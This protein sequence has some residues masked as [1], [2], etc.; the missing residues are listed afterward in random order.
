MEGRAAAAAADA[1]ERAPL[2][3][4]GHASL[5]SHVALVLPEMAK[6][7]EFDAVV[8]A[9][10]AGI[11]SGAGGAGSTK[12]AASAAG[13]GAAAAIAIRR[14]LEPFAGGMPLVETAGPAMMRV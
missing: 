1:A 11:L 8:V 2:V 10:P 14:Y 9:E 3:P 4:Y 12:Q 13:E 5:A 6:G 7:L